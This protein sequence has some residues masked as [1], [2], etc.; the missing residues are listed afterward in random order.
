MYPR[1]NWLKFMILSIL[2]ALTLIFAACS[3]TP[4]QPGT[5]QEAAAVA[6]T[7]D[8]E[9]AM[10]PE[11]IDSDRLLILPGR[12]R[13]G[14]GVWESVTASNWNF[15]SEAFYWQ[16]DSHTLARQTR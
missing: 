13:L 12:M 3:S 16:F 8:V 4:A 5:G 1:K 9:G 10:N 6:D 2:A 15:S 14:V 7:V 11:T